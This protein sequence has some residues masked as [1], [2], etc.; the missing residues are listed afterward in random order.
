M[1]LMSVESAHVVDEHPT[2]SLPCECVD[3]AI[4]TDQATRPGCCFSLDQ[5]TCFRSMKQDLQHVFKKVIDFGTVTN[6]PG[7]VTKPPGTV[8]KAPGTV[9]KKPEPFHPLF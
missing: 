3:S 4:D 8:T 7:T 5:E 2:S 6:P 1:N 9:T